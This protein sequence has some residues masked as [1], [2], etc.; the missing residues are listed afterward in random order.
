MLFEVSWLVRGLGSFVSWCFGFFV[1]V[2][3]TSELWPRADDTKAIM[4]LLGER[5]GLD[6][7]RLVVSMVG[8]I[9]FVWY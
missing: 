9:M 3:I 5:W 8:V 1:V 7:S 4:V 6:R 2:M